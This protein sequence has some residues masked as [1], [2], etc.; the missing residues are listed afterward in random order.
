M[1]IIIPRTFFRTHIMSLATW[2]KLI[3]LWWAASVRTSVKLDFHFR[4]SYIWQCAVIVVVLLTWQCYLN[5]TQSDFTNVVYVYYVP[6]N[7]DY[8]LPM[9][10]NIFDSR[11]FNYI[12]INKIQFKTITIRQSEVKNVIFAKIGGKINLFML[13][14]CFYF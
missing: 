4:F 11:N 8:Y 12:Y 10:Q 5:K 7:F 6:H 1:C 14:R 3:P 2:V 9:F 13:H